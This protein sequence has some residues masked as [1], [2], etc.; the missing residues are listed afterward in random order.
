MVH[1]LITKNEGSKQGKSTPD[2]EI[3]IIK[4]IITVGRLR[5]QLMTYPSTSNS[6]LHSNLVPTVV[7]ST[8]TTTSKMSGCHYCHL[9]P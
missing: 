3:N 7:V 2:K 9:G 4:M 6:Q 5:D 1:L 8:D